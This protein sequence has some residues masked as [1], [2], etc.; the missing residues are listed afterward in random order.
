MYFIEDIMQLVKFQ[1]LY[2]FGENEC[3][4]TLLRNKKRMVLNGKVF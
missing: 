2:L 4:I 1:I 3:I